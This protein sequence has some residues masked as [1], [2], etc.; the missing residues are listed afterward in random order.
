MFNYND[1]LNI[2]VLFSRNQRG[3]NLNEL[4]GLC[5]VC[6]YTIFRDY[7]REGQKPSKPEEFYTKNAM[8]I[9]VLAYFSCID[10]L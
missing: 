5:H 10:L 9:A 6:C 1:F 3:E 2:C 8:K 4:A 7:L